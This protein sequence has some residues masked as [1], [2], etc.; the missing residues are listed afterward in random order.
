MIAIQ[1]SRPTCVYYPFLSGILE[2][3]WNRSEFQIVLNRCGKTFF[4]LHQAVRL[5]RHPYWAMTVFWASLLTASWTLKTPVA[6]KQWIEKHIQG[7]GGVIRTVG[8][9]TRLHNPFGCIYYL[10]TNQLFRELSA[11]LNKMCKRQKVIRCR[12]DSNL[13]GKIPMDF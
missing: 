2:C 7:F 3:C 6:K 10:I 5:G 1:S 12:Q 13:R 4:Q 11:R 8:Y 9:N